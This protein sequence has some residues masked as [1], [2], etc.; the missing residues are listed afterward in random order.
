[1]V[2]RRKKP[3]WLLVRETDG[4]TWYLSL[5]LWNNGDT[6]TEDETLAHRFYSRRSASDYLHLFS[7]ERRAAMRIVPIF[8]EG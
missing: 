1:M 5:T 7:R 3:A 2:T 8:Q 6:W 4:D